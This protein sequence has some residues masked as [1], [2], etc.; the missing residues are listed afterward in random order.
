MLKNI[1]LSGKLGILIFIFVTGSIIQGGYSI[2]SLY[3]EVLSNKKE[4]VQDEVRAALKVIEYF[5]Q[6]RGVLGDAQSKILAKES[7]RRLRIGK[8]GYIWI[9]DYQHKMLMHPIVPDNEGKDMTNAKDAAGKYHIQEMVKVASSAKQE[10]FISYLHNTPA[11]SQPEE[12]ISYVKG[13]KPWGWVVGTGLY[14]TEVN[15]AYSTSLISTLSILTITTLVVLIM[16]GFIAKS[17]TSPIKQ[18]LLSIQKIEQG[19]FTGKF[20]TDRKDEIG[21]LIN[22]IATMSKNLVHLIGQINTAVLQLQNQ[23]QTLIT[24]S[25]KTSKNMHSQH[26]QVQ[27]ITNSMEEMNSAFKTMKNDANDASKSTT[28]MNNQIVLGVDRM[29]QGIESINK[30][31]ESMTKADETMQTLVTQ[32]KEIDQVVEVISGISEQTNLLALNAAIEAARAGESGRGFAVVADEVRSLAQRTQESTEQI[33]SMI[34]TLQ[35]FSNSVAEE[36]KHSLKQ[37]EESSVTVK[38]TE[39][40]LDK[41]LCSIEQISKIN[42]NISLSCEQQANKVEQ[43]SKGLTEIHQKA[44]ITLTMAEN[45]SKTSQDIGNS[46][47]ALENE[48]KEFKL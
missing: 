47:D 34:Q 17:I 43:A 19:D 40:E 2:A 32:S 23:T 8:E 29:K 24:D 33:K 4:K 35:S 22:G 12:K 36:M 46:S 3:D 6:Q 13:F 1:K 28:E 44:E 48:I 27:V 25:S 39:V 9:N 30:L 16:S 45:I 26:N 37:S 5:Y 14:L 41:V 11:F 15:E 42:E 7:L 38:E 31:G 21:S 18:L 20:N 10:G